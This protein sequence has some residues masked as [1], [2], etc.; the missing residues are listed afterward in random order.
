MTAKFAS[1]L[2]AA[3]VFAPIALVTLRQ[4]AQIYA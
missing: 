4:A 3:L 2:L 1:I